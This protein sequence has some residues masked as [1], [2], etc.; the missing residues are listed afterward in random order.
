[1]KQRYCY[2]ALFAAGFL[3][4][5]AL[6]VLDKLL[7]MALMPE[8]AA[9]V[10]AVL[11]F[12]STALFVLNLAIYMALLIW[13][14][15][16][17]HRRLLP[18]KGRS[19]LLLAA[20]FML[21]FLL[22][23]A[24]KYRL[25]EYG[26]L[27]EHV[28]WYAYY[29]PLVMIPALFLLACLCMEPTIRCA[30]ALRRGVWIISASLIL[31]VSSNDLHRLMFYPL[32]SGYQ[33]GAF[34]TYA[35]G[36]L[37]YLVYAS[38][39]LFSLL[40]V[41]LLVRASRSHGRRRALL[42]VLLLVLTMGMM[43]LV[44]AIFGRYGIPAPYFFPETFIFGMLAL[45]E[46]C[47]RSRLIPSN[48]NYEG[49]FSQMELAAEITDASFRP[50]YH[51]A[52]PVD[53]S[54]DQRAEALHAPLLLD[55]NTR[56]YVRR[57]GAGYVFWTGDESTLRRLNEEL[58]DAAEVLE[59]ENELLRYENEQKEKRARVDARNRVY[60]K[61]AAEVYDTQKKIAALLDR[62]GTGADA[63][64]GTLA[65]ILFL[66]A[67]VKRK[68]NFVL[69]SSER[70]TVSAEEL[71]LALEESA[72]F[73]CLCGI[74]ASVLKC[75]NRDFSILETAALYDSFQI[76]TEALLDHTGHLMITLTD[77]ALRLTA[78][79]EPPESLP[80]IPAVFAAESEGGQIYLTVLPR[81]EARHALL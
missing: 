64:K 5:G 6:H 1:M 28:C 17:V 9:S 21:L 53:A 80:E 78:E 7:N 68:T 57:L 12:G 25:V 42:P 56:L 62:L 38:V 54:D 73:L 50:V 36:L 63:E 48:E 11:A 49:F 18:S 45:F 27:L 65:R 34:G 24:V 81:E 75:A 26:S 58:E 8:S 76:L 70:D 67:Y 71:Y 31:G 60:A 19:Y 23:R 33:G 2:T 44:D 51:T 69:L 55:R 46:S 35:E 72:R 30:S 37:W 79:S 16:S 47:I 4:A 61:A 3:L 13:W 77:D 41:V 15:Q 40:G 14:L 74:D 59:T 29:I 52:Q 43:Y 39:I 10:S 22:E 32:D 20:G 66:N